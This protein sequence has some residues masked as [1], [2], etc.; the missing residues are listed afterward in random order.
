MSLNA[1]VI[2]VV[3]IVRKADILSIPNP[4]VPDSATLHELQAVYSA[5]LR[6]LHD[7]HT[8]QVAIHLEE[9][10]LNAA[11]EITVPIR[12]MYVGNRDKSLA[13]RAIFKMEAIDCGKSS[14]RCMV[15]TNT[16]LLN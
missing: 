14:R 16:Y 12:M 13:R 11:N 8:K 4:P 1:D 3:K 5:L 15:N 7:L 6:R 2:G 10:A 9:V